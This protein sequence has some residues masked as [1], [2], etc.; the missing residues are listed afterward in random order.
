MGLTVIESVIAGFQMAVDG[1]FS[2]WRCLAEVLVQ[3]AGEWVEIP[4]LLPS[5]NEELQA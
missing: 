1:P 3:Q 2:D 4:H 5:Q